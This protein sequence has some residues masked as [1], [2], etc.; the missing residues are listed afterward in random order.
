MSCTLKELPQHRHIFVYAFA[1]WYVDVCASG[2]T[3]PCCAPLGAPLN[4][5]QPP[6]SKRANYIQIVAPFQSTTRMSVY[7]VLLSLPAAA[8]TA[9]AYQDAGCTLHAG[10]TCAGMH[11]P[12]MEPRD[13][14]ATVQP[15]TCQCAG[16]QQQ[17]Y[18]VS[19]CTPM[20]RIIVIYQQPHGDMAPLAQGSRHRGFPGPRGPV[21]ITPSAPEAHKQPTFLAWRSTSP[22]RPHA[23]MLPRAVVCIVMPTTS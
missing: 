23:R 21:T 20:Y 7:T 19:V 1:G 17:L 3:A 5:G 2:T 12:W 8:A 16:T 18:A 13:H 22:V 14:H 15:S 6:R 10:F 11:K 4:R 9:Q